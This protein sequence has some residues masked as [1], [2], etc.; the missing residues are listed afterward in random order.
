M[1]L[2]A[3][4]IQLRLF[5]MLQVSVEISYAFMKKYPLVSG[6]LLIFFILY[7]FLSFIYNLLVFLSP[8]FV[9]TAIFVR[10]F[11]SSEQTQVRYVK[12]E[13][14]KVEE[15][16]VEPKY[17]KIPM[18][19]RNERRGMLYKFPSQNATSRR[20]NF[21]GRKLDVYGGLEEK[22][23]DLSAVF[24]NEFIKRDTD[25]RGTKFTEKK[26][27]NR[28]SA[29]AFEVPKKQAL[30]SEPS[31]LDLV[32]YGAS[33]AGPGKKTEN[34]EDGKKAQEDCNKV[35]EL[36][37]DDQKKLM[38][39]GVCEMETNKRL[40]S[41]IAR[42]R[43]RKQL[44]L[45]IENGL[46][47][48]K[49]VT[50]SQIAPLLISRANPFDSERFDDIEMPGS[51]P[52]ALRSPFDLPYGPFEEKPNLTGDS[53]HQEF[54]SHQLLE[55]RAL[56]RVRRLP[57]KVNQ[58]RLEQLISQEGGES[59]SKA[60]NSLSE[61][62]ETTHEEDGKCDIDMVG[63]KVEEVDSV[64][65]TKS[66]LDNASEPDFI[67]N[68]ERVSEKPG[69]RRFPKP[70]DR[71]LDFPISST[72]VADINDSLYESLPSPVDKNKEN[73]LF[74][75]RNI[76][77]TPSHS[78]A[79]DLQ[80]EV[81]EIG[82]PTLT[83]DENHDTI[84]TM[85]GEFEVYDGDIDKEVTSGSKDMWGASLHS[86][87][88][89][90][91]SSEQDISEVNIDA[92]DVADVC[93][94]SS[95]SDMPEDNPTHA[96]SSDHNI[97]G[98][99]KDLVRETGSLQPSHS[100][101]VIN[102]VNNSIATEQ[103]NT[104]NS[105]SS[106]DS[107]ASVVRQEAIDEVSS[108]S[109]STSSPRSVLPIPQKTIA[110]QVTSSAYNNQE[111]HLGV[112]QSYMEDMAQAT[113]NGEGPLDSMPQNIQPSMDDPNVESHNGDLSHSQEQTYPQEN[114]IQEPDMSSKM[115]N[116][117]ATD[118]DLNKNETLVLSE[119]EGE[120]DHVSNIAHKNDPEESTSA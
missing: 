42:R 44:N 76:R 65:A 40:E 110:D 46:I 34:M 79:S 94:M 14:K 80:V 98:N 56:P 19:E 16:R 74:T 20:R 50:P 47:D 66:M 104:Q 55:P 107:G 41:L 38:D 92:E 101:Q 83:V 91:V 81:S 119:P 120:S 52:S 21:S 35:V 57:G 29:K 64:D 48:N 61:G 58:D 97:F 89:R 7:I 90:G 85:D 31:M 22:A 77:H 54:T 68:V 99:M 109:S 113:L 78:L 18:Y 103:E 82:S 12:K 28:F 115:N 102:D 3:R 5:R 51:A 116:N 117:E 6:A 72:S 23:K 112:Q 69:P 39:L 87:E 73:M 1:D 106:E 59:E 45:Q 36:A 49:S 100:S 8:F 114:S 62:E 71:V 17:P 25:I 4:D 84:T 24:H 95:R 33:C 86:R 105:N 13:E 118:R 53:F 30:Y 2:N 60:P 96:I 11:W 32:T 63:T 10:I 108:N 70:N 88:V 75:S 67:P 15:K 93:S 9:C 26:M 43:A 111:G 37:E 27:D